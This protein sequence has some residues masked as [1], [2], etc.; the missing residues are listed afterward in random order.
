MYRNIYLIIIILKLLLFYYSA[1]RLQKYI[2]FSCLYNLSSIAASMKPR[3]KQIKIE[4]LKLRKRES[5]HFLMTRTINKP[6]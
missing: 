5:N 1:K 2:A 3:M 4:Y 6:S